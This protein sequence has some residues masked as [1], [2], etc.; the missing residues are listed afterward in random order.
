MNTWFRIQHIAGVAHVHIYDFIGA[1]GLTAGDLL[2]EIGNATDV[3][4]IIDSCGGDAQEGVRLFDGLCARC[5]S[6]WIRR[7]CSTGVLVAMAA[8]RRK[9]FA[10]AHV[11]IHCPSSASF[12]SSSDLRQSAT[13]LDGLTAR[14]RDIISK[15]VTV[16]PEIVQGWLSGPDVWFDA[17]QALAV[18][19]ADEVLPSPA[20][21][22]TA[23]ALDNSV[24]AANGTLDDGSEALLFELLQALGRVETRDRRRLLRDLGQWAAI[25]VFET[26]KNLPV[27]NRVL[28]RSCATGHGDGAGAQRSARVDNF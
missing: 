24:H 18:G 11:M 25:S 8:E 1:F 15:R 26:T 9:I 20:E 27:E 16:S 6:A 10:D 7:A 14:W 2:K 19:L 28:I 5:S 12:G 23:D 3:Q 17:Q 13:F 22:P 21:P 4:L